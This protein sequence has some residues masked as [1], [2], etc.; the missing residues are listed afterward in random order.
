MQITGVSATVKY[1]K[2]MTDGSWKTVQ[3]VA[4]AEL[5]FTD[6]WEVSQRELYRSLA[7]QLKEVWSSK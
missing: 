2:Q 3:L 4:E 6:D 5:D 1:S 7:E